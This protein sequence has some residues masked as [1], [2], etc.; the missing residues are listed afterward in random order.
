MNITKAAAGKTDSLPH[1]FLDGI[2]KTLRVSSL[3]P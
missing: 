3:Y 2:G 1:V